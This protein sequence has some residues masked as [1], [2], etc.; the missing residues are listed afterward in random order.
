MSV[1]LAGIGLALL[2]WGSQMHALPVF[3][4]DNDKGLATAESALIKEVSIGGLKRQADGKL[5]KTYTGAPP[6]ACP[7]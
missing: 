2:L 1:V 4:E 7:T 6:Q 3:S 5:Y